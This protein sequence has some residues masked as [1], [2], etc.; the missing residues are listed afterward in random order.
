MIYFS[1]QKFIFIWFIGLLLSGSVYAEGYWTDKKCEELAAIAK[2]KWAANEIIID[3]AAQKKVLF[4][5]QYNLF[6]KCAIKAGK[7]K[8]DNAAREIYLRCI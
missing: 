5:F 7:A 1:M 3:C 4:S 8:T 2:N 6:L